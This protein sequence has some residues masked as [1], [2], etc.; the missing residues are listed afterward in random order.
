MKNL[1]LPT[2][3]LLFSVQAFADFN[4]ANNGKVVE[5]SSADDQ[6]WVLNAQRTTVKFTIEGETQ[7]AKKITK[8]DSDGDTFVA[9]TTSEGV[10]TLSDRGDSFQFT[11]EESE[12]SL[13]CD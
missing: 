2:L 4:L 9:Y 5:C 11:G 3:T 6:T 10:L 1:I 8:R 13:D 7:G 12:Q